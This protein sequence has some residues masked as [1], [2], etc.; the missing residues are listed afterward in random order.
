MATAHSLGGFA[1][2]VERFGASLILSDEKFEE[3]V[4]DAEQRYR[5]DPKGYTNQL[6]L[7]A[8]M[9]YGY[10]A[11]IFC[12]FLALVGFLIYHFMHT[13]GGHYLQIKLL[14]ILGLPLWFIAKSMWVRVPPPEGIRVTRDD[15]PKLFDMLDEISSALNTKVDKVLICNDFNAAITQVPRFGLLGFHENYLLLG[16]PLMQ[17]CTMAQYKSILAHEFGHLSGN[18]SKVTA[19]IYMLRFR[20]S[21]LL[22]RMREE[23]P[24]VFAIFYIFFCWYAPRYNAYSMTIARSHEIEADDASAKLMKGPTL[25]Q[26]LVVTALKGRYYG[27]ELWPNFLLKANDSATPPD[28]IFA[29]F[30]ENLRKLPDDKD[31]VQSWLEDALKE[32]TL[33]TETHPCLAD[34]L[35]NFGQLDFYNDNESCLEPI[36]KKLAPGESAADGFLGESVAKF[37]RMLTDEWKQLNGAGWAQR[38]EVATELKKALKELDEKAVEKP[39]TKS[40]LHQKAYLVQQLSGVDD[41]IPIYRELLMTVDAEDPVSNYYVGMQLLDKKDEAGIEM[42]EKSTKDFLCMEPAMGR[43]MRYLADNGREKECEPILH[44]LVE[45]SKVKELAIAERQGVTAED[46]FE[47]HDLNAVWVKRVVEQLEQMREVKAIYVV[48]KV[49]RHFPDVSYYVVGLDASLHRTLGDDRDMVIAQTVL[50]YLDFPG[51]FCVTVFDMMSKKLRSRIEAVE[52]SQIY[53]RP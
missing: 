2:S 37:E 22:S 36:M 41:A 8:L 34:R 44:R 14:I 33:G 21:S 35:K 25:A 11:L 42:L 19:W 46:V 15:V 47:P 27:E 17:S 4:A 48:R 3:M 53:K 1:E 30:G 7:F 10:I 38:H 6:V 50:A 31:K 28:T 23:S 18:H 49:V 39:L 43:V 40:D 51:Q 9:A 12:C 52:G 13:R 45:F 16:L 24:L 20:W 26:S 32:K 5:Q 29:D